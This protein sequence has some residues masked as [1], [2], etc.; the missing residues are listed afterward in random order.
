MKKALLILLAICLFLNTAA[1]WA[2]T[3]IV[4]NWYEIFV[5]SYADGDGDRIGDFK[6]LTAK[7]DYIHD[8]GFGGIWLMPIH[9]SPSY[10]KYDVTDYYG[11]HEEY[12]TLEDF[13]AFLDK[14]H[15]LN[16]RV[17]IDLVVNHT[18]SRHPWFQAARD[19]DSPYREYYNFSAEAK[20]GYN[21]LPEGVYYES[22]FTS[23]MPDLNLDSPDV[24]NEIENI[25]RYWLDM[26][27]D[28][29]R[30]DAVTSYYTGDK[31]ANIAFLA[32][33]NETCKAI[34][35]DCFI[36]GECWD[37]LRT[38]RDY[39]ESGIDSFFIFPV[40]QASGY[41]GSLLRADTENK[42]E[43]FGAAVM[44]LKNEMNGLLLSPFLGNHDTPRI[45]NAVGYHSATNI[46]M[47]AGLLAMMKGCIFVYYGDEIGMV[48]AA[49]DPEKRL[50]MFWDEKK[51]ITFAP[52][53]TSMP[54][55]PF[56]SVQEQQQKDSSILNYYKQAMH[57][58]NQFP[59][60][61]RGTPEV[62][63]SPD[64]SICLIEK[65]HLD[66]RLLI[67]INLSVDETAVTLP[68]AYTT[69]AGELQVWGQAELE[70]STLLLPAYG[71]ALIQ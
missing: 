25:M 41:I 17:I 23:T 33:L 36:V 51:N 59:V 20:P 65:T 24:L 43:R 16:I 67:A 54:E 55:Y 71:I 45:A 47:A 29:F 46:K 26:G 1:V 57:L 11:I 12:G 10:H 2:E 4:D 8:L 53:G 62:L 14:A 21:Y 7:L 9:P 44:L 32:W 49:N 60:I 22:R 38:I 15:A 28:G 39:Y 48:G 58:R 61:A 34:K 69:L 42:A 3:D 5:Y 35:P 19:K 52:P 30:L 68:G 13:Q 27:V 64:G 6:G 56:P 18:S 70:G 66:E 63:D 31:R 37:N 40:S 50:G